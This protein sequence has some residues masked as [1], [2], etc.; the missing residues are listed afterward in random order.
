[1]SLSKVISPSGG[2]NLGLGSTLNGLQHVDWTFEG[3]TRKSVE[4][5]NY[6][7]RTRKDF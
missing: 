7:I 4:R 5:Y 2:L 1:M 6:P 3:L